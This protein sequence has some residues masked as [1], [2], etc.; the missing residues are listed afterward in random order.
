MEIFDYQAIFENAHLQ[1][2]ENLLKIAD[3][4]ILKF[5]TFAFA[6]K[7]RAT[8]LS[9]MNRLDEAI[10]SLFQSLA[11]NKTD[12]ESFFLLGHFL[13]KQRRFVDALKVI[14]E[15]LLQHPAQ[16]KAYVAKANIL[17]CLYRPNDEI[18]DSLTDA[19]LLEENDVDALNLL[20]Q[21]Y[22]NP[23]FLD[24][25]LKNIRQKNAAP[26]R[27]ALKLKRQAENE[28]SFILKAQLL[29]KATVLDSENAEYLRELSYAYMRQGDY[30]KAVPLMEKAILKNP[31]SSDFSFESMRMLTYPYT[32]ISA[33]K[34]GDFARG[35]V[36]GYPETPLFFDEV[37]PR[38]REKKRLK[39]GFLSADLRVH[40]VTKFLESFLN[41]AQ[42]S[43]LDFYAYLTRGIFDEKSND[44]KR[45]F[46]RWQKIDRLTDEDVARLIHQDR[47]DILLDLSG[48]TYGNRL[49][50]FRYRPAPVSATW[51]GWLGTTGM[52]GVDYIL[53]HELF[54]SNDVHG[55]QF[56]EKPVF[57]AQS[58]ACFTPPDPM[59]DVAP[60]PLLTKGH[61]TFG[62]FHNPNKITS[63][64]V[65]LWAEVL[66]ELPKSQ[67][68]WMRG[69]LKDVLLR[70]RFYTAFEK[71]GVA[72]ACNRIFLKH[73]NNPA[74]YFLAHKDVDFV[75][76][77]FPASSGTTAFD[78]AFMGV[79][80][81]CL[82]GSLMASRLSSVVMHYVDCADWI[83]H[84][85]DEFVQK[86]V[87]FARD[88]EE[89]PQKLVRL[90][91]GL[92]KQFL[93]SCLCDARRFA[94]HFEE[95]MWR[96]WSDR[97]S[98][99]NHQMLS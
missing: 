59:P 76:D 38:N 8:A 53:C 60:A 69:E 52:P 9:Q 64:T 55:V 2:P 70:E 63:S 29:E 49:A 91:G 74:E 98:F 90:R 93:Q 6:Y 78:S 19:L 18:L 35:L 13:A 12:F 82:T 81:L 79:P 16:A 95:L 25:S 87:R 30:E 50:V 66:N 89:N 65:A 7:A 27:Q 23:F 61:I 24:E 15:S 31:D 97:Q 75:L 54:V 77:S 73:N 56:S 41:A 20:K 37:V 3:E 40:A 32:E 17:Y 45:Y 4:A 36:H 10:E 33:Q 39:I 48:L 43:S 85:K 96:L 99:E 22:K 62:A 28:K 44:M 21:L 80:T 57:F 26:H 92:R 11:Y 94:R 72:N 71:A 42:N 1:Q 14:D 67:L 68:V 58:W 47:I 46:R 88:F 83:A 5:P 86:A 84:S 34:M 51:L